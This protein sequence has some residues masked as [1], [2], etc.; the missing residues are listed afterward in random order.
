MTSYCYWVREERG[1]AY[2]GWVGPVRDRWVCLHHKHMFVLPR[3]HESV[4][5][6][7]RSGNVEM[8][9]LIDPCGTHDW[10]W[11]KRGWEVS[12]YADETKASEAQPAED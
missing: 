12:A 11:A 10:F 4:A 7:V 2:K 9:D 6:L 5:A 1:I 8:D 3:V